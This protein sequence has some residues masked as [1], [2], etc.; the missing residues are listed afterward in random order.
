M[1]HIAWLEEEITRLDKERQAVLKENPALA[2]RAD[3]YRTVPEV[4]PLTVA[5]LVAYLPELG[6]WDSKALTSPVGLAR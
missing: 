5:T 2:E 1:C 4:G 6:H 3:L